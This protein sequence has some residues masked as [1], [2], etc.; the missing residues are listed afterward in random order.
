MP[1]QQTFDGLPAFHELL[2]DPF[3]ALVDQDVEAA[4]AR[5]NAENGWHVFM[6]TLSVRPRVVNDV[7]LVAA[8]LHAE[9]EAGI[10][11]AA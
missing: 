4:H 9:D 3:E 10:R 6:D 5:A 2:E 1:Y 11:W 8:V 7:G